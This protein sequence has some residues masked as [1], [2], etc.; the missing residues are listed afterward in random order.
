MDAIAVLAIFIKIPL[1]RPY[2]ST[3]RDIVHLTI[4]HVWHHWKVFSLLGHMMYLHMLNIGH[5][6]THFTN[7]PKLSQ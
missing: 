2:F 7:V 5:F 4:K 3:Y 6:T 1:C